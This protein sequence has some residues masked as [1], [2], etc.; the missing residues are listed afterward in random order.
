MEHI[1]QRGRI[2]LLRFAQSS[3]STFKALRVTEVEIVVARHHNHR[4][5]SRVNP[6]QNLRQRFLIAISSA[7]G[8]VAAQDKRIRPGFDHRVCHSIAQIFDPV[9]HRVDGRIRFLCEMEIRTQ[10]NMKLLPCLR[11]GRN[12][13]QKQ[14]AKKQAAQLFRHL[15]APLPSREFSFEAPPNPKHRRQSP[16]SPV[17]QGDTRHICQRE[18]ALWDRQV[19]AGQSAF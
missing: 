16:S 3:E 12:R 15:C 19:Q 11:M 14:Q 5:P 2:A 17:P 6:L 18:A 9:H 1:A 13:K 10:Q 8:N 4:N 7:V